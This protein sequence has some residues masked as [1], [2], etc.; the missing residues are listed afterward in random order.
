VND[1]SIPKKYTDSCEILVSPKWRKTIS[2]L[3]RRKLL[4]L[5]NIDTYWVGID[6]VSGEIRYSE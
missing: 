6:N 1:S 3:R 5:N 2:T 4:N